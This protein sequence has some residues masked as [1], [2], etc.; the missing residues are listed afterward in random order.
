MH[1]L[2]V[3]WSL[4]GSPDGVEQALAS[5]VADSSHARLTDKEGL[6]RMRAGEW[7]EVGATGFLAAPSYS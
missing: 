2:T 5:Y 1:R 6:R 7:F 3:R 4:D